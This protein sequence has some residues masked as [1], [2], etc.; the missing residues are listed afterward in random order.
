MKK[1]R[2]LIIAFL[3]LLA[4]TSL[5]SIALA[6][7]PVRLLVNGQE[8]KPD[9]PPR[10]INGRVMLPVRTIAEALGASVV[11]DAE[12]NLVL[13]DTPV[14]P[15]RNGREISILV[16]GREVKSVVL[17]Q[18]RGGRVLV[19]VR[20]I[21]EAL[22][23]SVTWQPEIRTVSITLHKATDNPLGQI[24][25]DKFYNLSFT[26]PIGWGNFGRSIGWVAPGSKEE[27]RN[28]SLDQLAAVL[29]KA[30]VLTS[31]RMEDKTKIRQV[32][33]GIG[34]WQNNK[35]HKHDSGRFTLTISGRYARL[36]WPEN[37]PAVWHLWF[38]G[39]ELRRELDKIEASLPKPFPAKKI[40]ARTEPAAVLSKSMLKVRAIESNL[41]KGLISSFIADPHTNRYKVVL[42]VKDIRAKEDF[43]YTIWASADGRKWQ[44]ADIFVS[45]GFSP[46]AINVLPDKSWLASG[47]DGNIYL[48][49]EP[50]PGQ[51]RV[52]RRV[53]E[54]PFPEATLKFSPRAFVLDPANPRRVYAQFDHSTFNPF[55]NGLLASEDGGRTWSE[56]GVN[57]NEKAA[58]VMPGRPW[59]D[60]LRAGW[61]YMDGGLSFAP[62]DEGLIM[63]PGIL[64][65]RDSGRTWTLLLFSGSRITLFGVAARAENTIIIGGKGERKLVTS[66]DGGTTWRERELP[67][68]PWKIIFDAAEPQQLVGIGMLTGSNST[69]VRLFFSPD[70]GLSWKKSEP[71]LSSGDLL[72]FDAKNGR[73]F[74][75]TFSGL[76][77]YEIDS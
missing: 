69:A 44:P 38:P 51:S 53:W 8:L 21:T 26:E 72:H 6:A 74:I 30:E 63:G 45:M 37:F 58:L 13:V 15:E 59:P 11:W 14:T 76:I 42:G 54:Y 57:G 41:P 7:S 5:T 60:P 64:H 17:P 43:T 20:V 33:I 9:T 66:T 48:S 31:S 65:T 35:G 56:T 75:D 52:W 73:V 39:D 46:V 23:A 50:S 12:K 29:R 3:V 16:R 67:F 27:A 32:E 18:L 49:P 68:M 2:L 61:L 71:L 36:E 70:G 4:L 62:W 1:E 19:P 28:N 10:I 24:Q 47:A 34:E 55:S 25:N 77:V 40:E 22:D